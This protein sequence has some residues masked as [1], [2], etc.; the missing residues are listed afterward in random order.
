MVPAKR[1]PVSSTLSW[2]WG[3]GCNR[4]HQIVGAEATSAEQMVKLPLLF[5]L[6]ERWRYS[7]GRSG[8][9][10]LELLNTPTSV[11]SRNRSK[12]PAVLTLF[13]AP[14]LAVRY[15][16]RRLHSWSQLG[17]RKRIL[18]SSKQHL[19]RGWHGGPEPFPWST[20]PW[21]T[22]LGFN[23]D[24]LDDVHLTNGSLHRKDHQRSSNTGAA[25]VASVIA[26]GLRGIVSDVVG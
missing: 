23:N 3:Q 26:G 7:H 5:W 8:R 9:V 1:F 16:V 24:L 6:A 15:T 13:W 2:R 25:W 22:T 21:G 12:I 4:V 18:A 11:G 17:S 19:D 14:G 20:E 10:D